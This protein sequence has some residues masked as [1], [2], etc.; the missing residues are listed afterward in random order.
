MKEHGQDKDHNSIKTIG[1]IL[2]VKR[3]EDKRT[4]T[5]RT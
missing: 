4:A 3:E 2:E 1:A 5:M